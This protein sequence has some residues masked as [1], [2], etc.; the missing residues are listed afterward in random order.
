VLSVSFRRLVGLV[1]ISTGLASPVSAQSAISAG[2]AWGTKPAGVAVNGALESAA[3]HN[4]N[5]GVASAV[6]AAQKGILI[7]NGSSY[8]I[9]SVGSQTIVSSTIIGNDNGDVSIDADQT[10]SNSGSVSTDGTFNVIDIESN[11][12][13]GGIVNNNT[14]GSEVINNPGGD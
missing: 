4:A 14:S 11:P 9:T 12:N 1:A 13:A 6:N 3:S 5:G 10:S 2:T 8:S 7:G